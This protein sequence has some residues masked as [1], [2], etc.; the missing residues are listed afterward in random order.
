MLYI[1]IAIFIVENTIKSLIF[2]IFILKKD[3]TN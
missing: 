2:V 1:T 3:N